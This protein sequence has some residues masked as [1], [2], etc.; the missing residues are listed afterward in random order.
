[1][2]WQF[3]RYIDNLLNTNYADNYLDLVALGNTADMVSLLSFETKHIINKGFKSENIKN[4]FIYYMWRKN[5]FKLGNELTSWGVAFYIAPFVNAMVRSG[6]QEE[7]ELLFKSMLKK[8]AFKNISSTKRGHKGE[9]EKLVE[10]AI[11]TC[12]NVKN[13][14]T[15]AQDLGMIY[16]ESMIEK[17]NLLN[18]KVLLFLLEPGEIDKNIA[19]LIANKYMARYQRPCCI[20]TRVEENGIISYQGSARGCDKVGVIK[21]KDM[22]ESTGSVMYVAGHQSAFG[23]GVEEKYIQDF[24]NNTN[25]LLKDISDEP[26]YYVD[27]IFNENNIEPQIILDIAEMDKY[28]GKDVDESLIAIEKLKVTEN[29]ITL[30]SPDKSPTLKIKIDNK[31]SLIKFGSSQEEY[32]KLSTK[33]CVELNIIGRCNKNEWNGNISAQILIEDYEIIDSAKYFF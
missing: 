13:R 12:T 8:E 1:M 5:E 6:T 28:W 19:G 31:V 10:Q 9:E 32:D 25:L 3:C 11:R 18:D 21:F 14:Q 22:C 17:Q 2:V 24:I 27:Y 16:L 7:K 33:G 29:M 15:K 30:M 20:L 26:I 23:L 4:P